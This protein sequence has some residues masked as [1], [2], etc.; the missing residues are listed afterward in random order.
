MGAH[1]DDLVG[2]TSLLSAKLQMHS[3]SIPTQ[4][5]SSVNYSER[6]E[7]G[8]GGCGIQNHRR[9]RREQIFKQTRATIDL[10]TQ[11]SKK[12]GRNKL[13][14]LHVSVCLRVCVCIE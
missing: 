6:K 8:T 1:I 14:K 11:S 13:N 4:L 12:Y 3:Q 9:V 10:K 2:S 7:H 5:H